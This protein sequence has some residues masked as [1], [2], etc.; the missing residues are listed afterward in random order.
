[1]LTWERKQVI[2][3]GIRENQQGGRAENKA[4]VNKSTCIASKRKRP[5]VPFR[6]SGV[7]RVMAFIWLHFDL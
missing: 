4:T 1:M 3:R 2:V 6:K 5:N 7:R